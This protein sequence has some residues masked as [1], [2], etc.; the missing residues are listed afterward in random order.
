MPSYP[1][2]RLIVQLAE[3]REDAEM[4]CFRSTSTKVLDFDPWARAVDIGLD[5]H[6]VVGGIAVMKL[7]ISN[8]VCT[9]LPT[10]VHQ[11]CTTAGSKYPLSRA[12]RRPSAL[13]K[14]GI[15]EEVTAVGNQKPLVI[16][17]SGRQ[18]HSHWVR[19]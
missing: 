1:F 11:S 14:E 17:T 8:C 15:A 19:S 6:D 13:T 18:S 12:R 7:D 2:F 3:L 4:S 10:Y 5:D 9:Y 16:I